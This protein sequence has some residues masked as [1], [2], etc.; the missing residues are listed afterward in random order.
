MGYYALLTTVFSV[1]EIKVNKGITR[2]I[3]LTDLFNNN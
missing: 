2:P 3:V 1:N